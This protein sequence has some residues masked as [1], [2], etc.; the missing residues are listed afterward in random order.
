MRIG[1]VLTNFSPLSESFLRREVLGMCERGHEVFVYTHYLHDDPLSPLPADPRLVVR[2]T[3]FLTDFEELVHRAQQDSIDHLHGSLMLQ[4]H[5]GAWRAARRLAVPFT[6]SA[7]SGYSVFT[8]QDPNLYRELSSDPLCGGIVSEDPFMKDWLIERLGA[9]AAKIVL[10]ANP[11]DVD[12]YRRD[13]E[14][15]EYQ[16]VRILAIARFVEKKG[17]LHLVK[18]F[19][20]LRS[21][22]GDL[23]LWL[24]GE[25]PEGDR[26]RQAAA[27]LPDIRFLGLRSEDEC[28]RAYQQCDIFCLPCVRTSDGD[29]DGVPTTVLEAMAYEMPVVASDLLSM[30]HYVRDGK[31][32]LL[33][34]PGDE[35]GIA[36]C[37]E[38][39][40][41]SFALRQQLGSAGRVRVVEL[42]ELGRNLDLLSA[43]FMRARE[44]RWRQCMESLFRYR[45][46]L[47]AERRTFHGDRSAAAAEY[48]EPKGRFLDIGC[49][50]GQMRHSLSGQVAY[51]GCDPVPIPREDHGFPFVAAFGEGLP[52]ADES[53]DCALIK[54]TLS[55]V[56]DIDTTLAEAARVLKPG[57]RLYLHECVNDQNPIHLNH[58]TDHDLKQRLSRCL[59]ILDFRFD[60]SRE[61]ALIVAEK[62]APP[63]LVGIAVTTFDRAPFLCGSVSIPP[64]T[65]RMHV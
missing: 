24:I 43:L 47:P 56:L 29:A 34:Q 31:E 23:E 1:Y 36:R 63:P 54:S 5:L 44:D 6:I 26:L 17:L 22:R 57:G 9:N 51:F 49:G 48:F 19:S 4:A 25:G 40:V 27:G 28:R 52:F 33:A 11:I 13:G 41:N 38:T 37:L 21:R 18:A 53:F 55:Y 42:C 64:S 10:V 20:Q 65:R 12:L 15:A 7:Y 58:Y 61:T 16:T 14:R 39:L 32:G 2:Q 59:S 50:G 60:G 45:M 46:E 3:R 8:S 35:D 62:A 30:S